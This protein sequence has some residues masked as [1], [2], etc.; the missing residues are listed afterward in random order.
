MYVLDTNV[1]IYAV[2][3]DATQHTR[4]SQWLQDALAGSE[5]IGLAWMVALGFVRIT[6]SPTIL[7]KPVNTQDALAVLGTLFS[8]PRVVTLTPLPNHLHVLSGLLTQAGSA[9]NLTTDAHIAALAIEHGAK[10]ASF[11]RDFERFGVQVVVP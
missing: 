1:L 2:N 7:T 4:A 10:V 11:D 9:G 5:V 3:T 8:Q 6:T